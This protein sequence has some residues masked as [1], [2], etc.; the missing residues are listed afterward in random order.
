MSNV[1]KANMGNVVC[2]DK[3]RALRA[4]ANGTTQ[5]D[6][7]YRTRIAKMSGMF[8]LDEMLAF[9]EHKKSNPIT[10]FMLVRGI[11]LFKALSE[12]AYTPELREMTGAYHR[13]LERDLVALNKRRF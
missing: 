3:A 5:D 6:V 12:R 7:E 13:Q 4:V 9:H 2:L 8:L 11:I 1:I 10:P